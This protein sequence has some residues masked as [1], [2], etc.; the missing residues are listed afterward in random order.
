MNEENMIFSDT[1]YLEYKEE[2]YKIASI[3]SAFRG[4]VSGGKSLYTK[5][6]TSPFVIG[7]S[8]G[9]TGGSLSS[10]VGGGAKNVGKAM[11]PTSKVG[12]GLKNYSN[13]L[14]EG[15]E[16]AAY[17]RGGIVKK[18]TVA[19]L[20]EDGDPEAVIPLGN[21]RADKKNRK[22]VIRQAIKVLKKER[23]TK[24]K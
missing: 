16:Q 7:A 10:L 13:L 19:R 21:D 20:A 4:A 24:K 6:M 5:A 1:A 18:P 11:S 22:R 3:A 23:G 14:G 12:K 8:M 15:L 9:G 2:M 17:K